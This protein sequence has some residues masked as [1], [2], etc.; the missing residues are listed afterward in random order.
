MIFSKK[1]DSPQPGARPGEAHI[2]F[3]AYHSES[4]PS[5]C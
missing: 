4:K 2:V 3:V 5:F 1:V